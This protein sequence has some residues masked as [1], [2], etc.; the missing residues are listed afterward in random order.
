VPVDAADLVVC[1]A[2]ASGMMAA[3][4]AAKT[5]TSFRIL[6]L[7]SQKHHGAKILVSGGGR[8]NLTHSKVSE[9]DYCGGSKR[10][11]SRVL[12]G[13]G[14]EKTLSFF[15]EIG[16]PC[17]G[18]GDGRVFPEAGGATVLAALSRALREAG[19]EIRTGSK[20]VSIEKDHDFSLRLADGTFV[21]AT[22]VVLATG[23]QSYPQTGSDGR[24]YELARALGHSIVQV[25]PAL[26][27][28]VSSDPYWRRLSGVA[29]SVRLS[30][31]EG[32]SKKAE[33]QGPLL[34]THAGFSGPAVLDI[35]RHWSCRNDRSGRIEANLLPDF[36]SENLD[37]ELVAAHTA[38]R[39]RA[40]HFFWKRFGLPE[41][42]VQAFF[43]K[44][45]FPDPELCRLSSEWRKRMARAF[46]RYALPI[47]EAGG[48]D[49][50]EVT[51]GG[52]ALEEVN[53]S[54]L[55][56]KKVPGLYFAGEILDVDGRMGGFNLQ[57]AWSSGA[58]AGNGAVRGRKGTA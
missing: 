4:F 21:S 18:E 17:R 35:S 27:G 41:R 6:L 52:V 54:T 56:S 9:S 30:F 50:A 28:L 2:G 49:E 8:C 51:A 57:W 47:K 3:L 20:V 24:G 48:F 46:C 19:V 38:G 15:E 58:V 12:A 33:S 7:D 34:F 10:F 32:D 1:G 25:A 26:V 29:L 22:R 44:N 16:V 45:D 42:F 53:A 13:F 43:A 31:F 55:E 36:N 5:K 39:Q 23:G 40:A 37:R 11:I 14:V